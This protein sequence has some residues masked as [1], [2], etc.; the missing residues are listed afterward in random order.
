[1]ALLDALQKAKPPA[2]KGIYLRKIALSSTM[3][4]GVRVEQSS[5]SI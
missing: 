3:G 2:S 5:I 1:V 4:A